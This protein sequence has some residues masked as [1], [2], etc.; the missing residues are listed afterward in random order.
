MLSLFFFNPSTINSLLFLL[1]KKIITLNPYENDP[2][3]PYLYS[4]SWFLFL[5]TYDSDQ[6]DIR[7][8]IYIIM[9]TCFSI[10]RMK[11]RAQVMYAVKADLNW[12]KRVGIKSTYHTRFFDTCPSL[13]SFEGSTCPRVL[14]DE[15]V[16]T[17]IIVLP[18]SSIV[19]RAPIIFILSPVSFIFWVL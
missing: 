10:R 13:Q 11:W 5:T 2:D 6:W 1:K 4:L 16:W 7:R 9:I 15:L 19:D 14:T 17:P 12:D 18:Y 8:L 3:S